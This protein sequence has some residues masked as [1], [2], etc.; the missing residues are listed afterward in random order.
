MDQAMKRPTSISPGKTP[1][2]NS[3]P[4]DV[5]VAIPYTIIVI[6]GGMRIPRVPPAAIE[7]AATPSGKLRLR[8][9]G[10]P[11]FPIAAQVAGDEPDIAAKSA[12]APRFETTNPPGIRVNQRSN[13]SYKSA[14]ALVDAIA[15]PIK[16]NI[17]IDNNAKLSSLP[18]RISGTSSS[19]PNPSKQDENRNSRDN[20]T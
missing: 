12:H 2:K 20:R 11:I 15:A 9:S 16:I 13:A 6:D 19:A 7:P 8:I 17:G 14:P 4:M 5:S 1:A 18:N 10:I 3:R